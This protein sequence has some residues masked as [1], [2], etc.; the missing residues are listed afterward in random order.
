[1]IPGA[2]NDGRP[3]KI[4]LVVDDDEAMRL[5]LYGMLSVRYQVILAIDGVD[6]AEKAAILPPPNLVIA[7][8]SMP[9]LDGVGMVHRIREIAGMRE[10]PI[11]FISGQ[12]L[13]GNL[14]AGMSDS[15]F[16]VQYV[17]KTADPAILAKK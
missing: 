5:A 6:G 11:I 14:L 2:Q 10:V 7:D 13:V 3:R 9:R 12:D 15:P 4:I 1:M 17:G 16:S 8:I